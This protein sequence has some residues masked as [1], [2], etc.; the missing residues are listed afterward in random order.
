MQ[1]LIRFIMAGR[2]QAIIIAV[3]FTILSIFIPPIALLSHSTIALVTLRHGWLFGLQISLLASGLLLLFFFTLIEDPIRFTL[4]I[5]LQW[6]PVILLASLLMKTVS[7]Q[8]TLQTTFAMSVI[9]LLLFY[10]FVPEPENFWLTLLEQTLKPLLIEAQ[11]P[12]VKIETLFAETIPW[13]TGALIAIIM[14]GW[15]TTLLLARYW[16]ATLYNPKG[17]AKEFQQ[18]SLGKIMALLMIAITI[19]SLINNE[20]KLFSELLLLGMVVFLFQGLSISHAMVNQLKMGKGWLVGLYIFLLLAFQLV[21]MILAI[22]GTID[23]FA[24]F[25]QRFSSAPS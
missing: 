8:R 21:I 6:L 22:V 11:M 3:L 25:R 19:L 14:L 23:N 7:W 20:S 2:T 18:I 24:K 1:R 16:Q 12:L 10:Y 5:L 13:M 4:L 17:F 9:A 15:I